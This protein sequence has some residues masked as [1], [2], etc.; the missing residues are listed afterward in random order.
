MEEKAKYTNRLIYEKSPYLLQHAHNPVDWYPWGEEAFEASIREQKPIFLSIGYSTCHWCHVMEKESFED[1]NIATA[2]NEAFINVKVDREELPGVDSLYMEFAQGMIAGASGWPLNMILTPNLHPFFATT[3]LPPRR[4]HGLIGL[5]ELIEQIKETWNSVEEREHLESQSNYILQLY[6]KTLQEAKEANKS[7]L[8]KEETAEAAEILFRMTDPVYGGI[9]GEPKFPMGYHIN[10]LLNYSA[11]K[12]DSRALFIVDRTLEMMHNGGIYDHLGGGFSRYSTDERWFLPHFEKMLY[13]NAILAKSYFEGWQATKK[14]LFKKT[15]HEIFHYLIREMMYPKGGFYAA[16]DAD[17]EGHE[18]FFYTWPYQEVMQILGE[19]GSLFCQYYQIEKEGNFEGRNILHQKLSLEDFAK[20]FKLDPNEL[21]HLLQ[22]QREKLWEVRKLRVPPQ[23]D[24]KIITAWNGL[25]IDALAKAA[26]AN[27]SYNYLEV[28]KKSAR[29]IR[30]NLFVNQRLKRS[31]C[32][33]QVS[34]D[35]VLEDYAA[36][37]KGLIS[38]F[39]AHAGTDWL[40]WALELCKTVDA[41]FKAPQGGYFQTSIDEKN[42]ILRKCQFSD[43]AE[44]SSNSLH[45]ENLLRIYDLTGEKQYLHQAEEILKISGHDIRNYPIGHLYQLMNLN[46]YQF[47]NRATLVIALNRS[48]SFKE[49]IAELL[50]THF[51]PH[52]TI[53]WREEDDMSLFELIPEL[54]KQCPLNGQTTLYVCHQ[55]HCQKP[56][57]N[58]KE[59]QVAIQAL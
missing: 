49:Q 32:D 22:S 37:I 48:S 15:Y 47:L 40:V 6:A 26:N 36:L 12:K 54:K 33:G 31:W 3:Y 57:T 4:S 38:L 58:L 43:G 42:I 41:L 51:I 21:S 25:L 59:M 2:M 5:S 23:K 8:Y 50:H 53:L 30:Q 10:F 24:T 7:I 46:R 52:R 14:P 9:R 11:T 19:S 35:G 45:C 44:P 56:L 29:F 34:L 39:E 17:S 16:E 55:G 13:D 20:N 1:L 27:D 28:A 18:G